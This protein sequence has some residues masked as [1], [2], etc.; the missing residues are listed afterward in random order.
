MFC[1]YCKGK[2]I[3]HG[4]RSNGKQRYRCCVCG[5]TQQSIYIYKACQNFID[6]KEITELY[7]GG[8]GIRVAHSISKHKKSVRNF[9][10][11]GKRG[12]LTDFV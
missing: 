6:E 1:Q 12:F 9:V 5:K 8:L 7:C 2:C 3:K 11:M 4:K 10:H